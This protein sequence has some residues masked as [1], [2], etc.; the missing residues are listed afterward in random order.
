MDEPLAGE[1]AAPAQL[2]DLLSLHGQIEAAFAP[3]ELDVR[4]AVAKAGQARLGVVAPV[5]H[6]VFDREEE[7]EQASDLDPALAGMAGNGHEFGHGSAGIV[8]RWARLVRL[9][10]GQMEAEGGAAGQ[11]RVKEVDR[12]VGGDASI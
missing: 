7:A 12:K 1:G 8:F 9:E 4:G 5:L 3:G 11:G 2:G 10:A 6:R